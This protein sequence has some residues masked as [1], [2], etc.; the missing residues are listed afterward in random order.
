MWQQAVGKRD[1]FIVASDLRGIL[2]L[3]VAWVH[4]HSNEREAALARG[5]LESS[6]P[7]VYG[8]MCANWQGALVSVLVLERV[9]WA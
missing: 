4:H 6:S 8:C 7:K 1:V 9:H 2:K 5:A 3:E